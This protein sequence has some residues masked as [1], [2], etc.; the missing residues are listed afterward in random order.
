MVVLQDM[1]VNKCREDL[2]F[3]PKPKRKINI[4]SGGFSLRRLSPIYLKSF[5]STGV[6]EECSCRS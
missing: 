4:Y 2:V 1:G 6:G 3:V 5:K